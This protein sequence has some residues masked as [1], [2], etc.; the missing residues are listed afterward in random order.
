VS[1]WVDLDAWASDATL[2][3]ASTAALRAQLGWAAHLGLQAVLLP[4]PPQP[5]ACAH[6]AQVVNQV[7]DLF[8]LWLHGWDS[9][10]LIWA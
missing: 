9:S 7:R 4:K 3:A 2:A 8:R 10:T 1:D 5:T 6:Y